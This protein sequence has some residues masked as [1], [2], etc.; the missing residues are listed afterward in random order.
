MSRKVEV[1]GN[2]GYPN[3]AVLMLSTDGLHPSCSVSVTVLLLA[4]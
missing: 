1:E 4:A 2:G 3:A